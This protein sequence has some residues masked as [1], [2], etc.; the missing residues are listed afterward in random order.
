MSVSLSS[1]Y[2]HSQIEGTWHHE[3]SSEHE[4]IINVS[5]P[6][7][8]HFSFQLS[9]TFNLQKLEKTKINIPPLPC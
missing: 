8:G 4:K 5:T 3:P 9:P 7:L 6:F 1:R 2:M